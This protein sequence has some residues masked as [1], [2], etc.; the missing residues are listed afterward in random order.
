MGYIELAS[1]RLNRCA[2]GAAMKGEASRK[3]QCGRP[4]DPGD[5]ARRV[6]NNLKTSNSVISR[7]SR[8]LGGL[9]EGGTYS[10]SVDMSA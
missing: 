6:S 1:D 9:F 7:V 10:L 2:T 3:N 5:V 4:S 8:L